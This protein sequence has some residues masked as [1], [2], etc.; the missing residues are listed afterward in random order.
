MLKVRLFSVYTQ[1][2]MSSFLCS[3]AYAES[4]EGGVLMNKVSKHGVTYGKEADCFSFYHYHSFDN[5]F[6]KSTIAASAKV[7]YCIK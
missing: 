2:V 6:H 3:Q 4:M 5:D 1:V 7:G